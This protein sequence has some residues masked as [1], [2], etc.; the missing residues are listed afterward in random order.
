MKGQLD[1]VLDSIRYMKELGIWIEVTTL[2]VPGMNDD[3]AE[4]RDIANFLVETGRDIPWH[5]SRFTPRYKREDGEPTPERTLRTALEIGRK[6]GLRYV[7]VGNMPGD[8]AENTRCYD[9]GTTLIERTGFFV[10]K[11]AINERGECPKCQAK[12]DGVGMGRA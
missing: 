5:I 11:N 1:G 9:C 12:I 4:L 8:P 10:R 2:I 6:A 3:P 7:Y